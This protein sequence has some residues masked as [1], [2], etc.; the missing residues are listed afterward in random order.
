MNDQLKKIKSRQI[1][2]TFVAYPAA[3]FVILQAVDFFISKW[4]TEPKMAPLKLNFI[5]GR[6]SCFADIEL[7]SRTL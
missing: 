7:E 4:W 1:W 2:R 5:D 6:I 3:A